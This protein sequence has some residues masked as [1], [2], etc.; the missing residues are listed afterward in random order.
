MTGVCYE[1]RGTIFGSI[2]IR[3]AYANDAF[4]ESQVAHITQLSDEERI[5]RWKDYWFTNVIFKYENGLQ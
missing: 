1:E 4:S 2:N 3:S 5:K